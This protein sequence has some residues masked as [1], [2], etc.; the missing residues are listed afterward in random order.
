MRTASGSSASWNRWSG[1]TTETKRVA[2]CQD[3]HELP[4]ATI[5]SLLAADRYRLQTLFSRFIVCTAGRL[6]ELVDKVQQ[7][8]AAAVASRQELQ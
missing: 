2:V 6:A 1:T 5:E 4:L 3:Q 7:T 8:A